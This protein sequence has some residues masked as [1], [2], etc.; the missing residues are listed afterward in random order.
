[1]RKSERNSIQYWD[2]ICTK[3]LN[4]LKGIPLNCILGVKGERGD[5]GYTRPV[6]ALVKG[7]RGTEGLSG[8]PGLPGRP[9]S[10]GTDGEY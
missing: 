1:M 7:M 6:G 8:L 10:P 5:P 3:L 2:I 4:D 9:G